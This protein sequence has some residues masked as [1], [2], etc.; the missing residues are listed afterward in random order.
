MLGVDIGGTKIDAYEMDDSGV[1]TIVDSRP[2]P[3]TYPDI[4]KIVESM[5]LAR[6]KSPFGLGVPGLIAPDGTIEIATN[7]PC[8]NGTNIGHDLRRILGRSVTL[9]N[10]LICFAI[11]ELN[12]GSASQTGC[13]VCLV[14]GT[15]IGATI[16]FD[17][18]IHHGANRMAG[19]IGSSPLI[20]V[21]EYMSI[22]DLISGAAVPL[23]TKT[24]A[25]SKENVRWMAQC[26][27]FFQNLI[28]F[29]DPSSI[30]LLGGIASSP[31][32]VDAIKQGLNRT[33]LRSPRG[34]VLKT[35]RFGESSGVRGATFLA[36]H[37]THMAQLR[38]QGLAFR[39]EA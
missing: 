19:E 39:F 36:S 32:F 17:G 31:G 23:S 25:G 18:K 14:F 7:V 2:T 5:V 10:H 8:L 28:Y 6:S 20:G 15:G 21:E 9:A 37:T 35:S 4:L 24:Q 16:I 22:E 30:V 27:R 11:S 29:Y 3:K 13:T 12:G 38:S 34:T 1:G 26:L 33:M